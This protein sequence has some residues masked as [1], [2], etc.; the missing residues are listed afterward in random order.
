[1]SRAEE[2]PGPRGG[3]DLPSAGLSKSCRTRHKNQLVYHYD[4]KASDCLPVPAPRSFRL[5]CPVLLENTSLHPTDPHREDR[6]KILCWTGPRQE[7][8]G[9]RLCHSCAPSLHDPRQL[10]ARCPEVHVH[11]RVQDPRQ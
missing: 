3:E 5:G 11:W 1:M 2:E 7:S 8:Q 4:T 10:L 6:A 9:W